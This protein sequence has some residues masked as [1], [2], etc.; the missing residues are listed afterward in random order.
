MSVENMTNNALVK[1][2]ARLEAQGKTRAELAAELEVPESTVHGWFARKT[3]GLG[4][5]LR[6]AEAVDMDPAV[7][8]MDPEQ[9]EV[10]WTAFDETEGRYDVDL[11]VHTL[12]GTR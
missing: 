12:R 7:L 9:V 2:A 10:M 5:L 6:I 8:I 3:L 11:L 1:A 4:T